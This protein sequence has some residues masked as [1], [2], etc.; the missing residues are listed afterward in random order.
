MVLEVKL[1]N[2]KKHTHDLLPQQKTEKKRNFPK[3]KIDNWISSSSSS[4]M[5]VDTNGKITKR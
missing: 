3:I 2:K 4:Q 1:K 5:M